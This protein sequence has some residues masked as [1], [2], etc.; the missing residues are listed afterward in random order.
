MDRRLGLAESGVVDGSRCG[1]QLRGAI[2]LDDET[3][4]CVLKSGERVG[5][6]EGGVEMG[7]DLGDGSVP[8][9]RGRLRWR[10]PAQ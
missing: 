4:H 9:R 10:V 3:S 2:A 5:V 1:E 8:G 7:E 6:G